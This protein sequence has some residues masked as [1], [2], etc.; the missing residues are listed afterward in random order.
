MDM[1]TKIVAISSLSY[2][3]ELI[4]LILKSH[5]PY[6]NMFSLL[7]KSRFGMTAQ[8][9][10]LGMMRKLLFILLITTNFPKSS[11]LMCVICAM[12]ELIFKGLLP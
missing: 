5:V 12:R 4:N 3:N 1:K 7:I 11:D 9:F 8:S 6:K 10:Y 2:E